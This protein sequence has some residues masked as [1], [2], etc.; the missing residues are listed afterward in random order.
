MTEAPAVLSIDGLNVAYGSVR[1]I[2]N[3]SLVVNQGEAVALIGANGAGKSTLFKAAIGLVRPRSGRIALGGRVLDRISTRGRALLGM[4]YSPE[5]RRIFPG[6]SVR[7]ISRSR[8][9]AAQGTAPNGWPWRLISFPR[10]ARVR[11]RSAGSFRA[12]SSRCWRSDGR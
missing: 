11:G 5:G 6:L 10:S 7:E 2:E 12:A 1:A 9:E 4:G 3:V 8:C